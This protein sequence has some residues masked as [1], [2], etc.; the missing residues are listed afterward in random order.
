MQSSSKC[1]FSVD[2]L[3][4][5]AG[6]S[7]LLAGSGWWLVHFGGNPPG[8]LNPQLC[9]IIPWFLASYS[10]RYMLNWHIFLFFWT[11]LSRVNSIASQIPIY[12]CVNTI[13][14]DDNLQSSR[15][16]SLAIR[17]TAMGGKMARWK[18]KMY[19]CPCS[20]PIPLMLNTNGIQWFSSR[21]RNHIFFRPNRIGLCWFFSW[22]DGII[23]WNSTKQQFNPENHIVLSHYLICGMV[24]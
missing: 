8:K 15:A 11:K 5:C 13:F 23:L 19:S 10:P 16:C 9:C 20:N 6:L 7:Q 3:C 17:D 24:I 22:R 12:Y 21:E 2:E 18:S 14:A 4:I 1:F